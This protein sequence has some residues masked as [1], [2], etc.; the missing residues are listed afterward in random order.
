MYKSGKYVLGLLATLMLLS[1]CARNYEWININPEKIQK[2]RKYVPQSDTVNQVDITIDLKEKDKTVYYDQSSGF[3]ADQTKGVE[4]NY[5][6]VVNKKKAGAFQKKSKGASI[7]K[8]TLATN[9]SKVD[10]PRAVPSTADKLN[11]ALKLPF[12]TGFTKDKDLRPIDSKIKSAGKNAAEIRA[13]AFNDIKSK[14]PDLEK[15]SK[16]AD[17]RGK[18]LMWAGLVLGLA[19]LAL[20][21]IFGRSAFIISIVGAVFAAIGFFIQR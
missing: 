9:N 14:N 11:G 16:Q 19:G 10:R 2:A 13:L 20:G 15:Q 12:K 6:Y 8:G 3:F 1:S 18:N 4:P 17:Q 21:F 7:S 5:P